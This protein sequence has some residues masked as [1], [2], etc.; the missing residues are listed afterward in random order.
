MNSIKREPGAGG[1]SGEGT[2]PETWDWRV[3][4]E[5]LRPRLVRT[6]L[7]FGFPREEAEDLVQDVL[8]TVWA[9]RPRVRSPE[10]YLVAMFHNRC[11]DRAKQR[12]RERGHASLE[13]SEAVDSGLAERINAACAVEGAFR[14]VG[15][16]CRTLIESYY[17]TRKSLAETAAEAGTTVNAIWKRIDTCLKRMRLCLV[18]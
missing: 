8:Q 6:G 4:D 3:L 9:K 18:R 14:M 10:A 2:R 13:G 7:K 15:P 1:R 17:L 16:A 11:C 5:S 12:T